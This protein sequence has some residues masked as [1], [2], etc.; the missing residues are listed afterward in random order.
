[1]VINDMLVDFLADS[2][3]AFRVMGLKSFKDLMKKANRRII[4]KSPRTY[5]RLVKVKA[6]QIK[7]ELLGIVAVSVSVSVY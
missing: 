6:K 1:M 4:L 7:K 3:V 2:A 5:S